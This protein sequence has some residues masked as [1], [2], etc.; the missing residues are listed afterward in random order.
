V[1]KVTF[2]FILYLT[3]IVVQSI[4]WAKTNEGYSRQYDYR[5]ETID[6][7]KARQA[8]LRKN[9]FEKKH[10]HEISKSDVGL[11]RPVETKKKGFGYHLGF[12]SKIYYSNNPLSTESGLYKISAGIWENSIHNN[13][14]LGAYDLRGS[15]FSPLIGISYTSFSHFGNESI[16]KQNMDFGSL[17]LNF[18]GIFSFGHGW[19]VRPSLGYTS[20]FSHK[21]NSAQLYSQLSPSIALSKNF[22]L[23]KINSFADWSLTY[24]FTDSALGGDFLDRFETAL[25]WGLFIPFSNFE[26]SPYVRV[27]LS[28]YSNQSKTDLG[29]NLGLDLSYNITD[30]M[31]LRVYSTLSTRSSSK[32]NM[33]FTRVDTGAGASLNARF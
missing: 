25:T 10:S 11:Q 22:S 21:S 3:L 26:F 29:A 9:S 13:F 27:S 18:A 4:S 28:D 16:R 24:N 33:D 32:E 23:G 15:T 31:A 17:N 8:L 6:Q 12:S 20:D 19:S 7:Y 14:L 2:S 30:W 1:K 5:P